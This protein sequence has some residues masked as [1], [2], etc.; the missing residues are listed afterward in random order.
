[1]NS[2]S[3]ILPNSSDVVGFASSW[4]TSTCSI[5]LAVS[6][7][8][9]SPAIR[10]RSQTP[11]QIPSAAS[12]RSRRMHR[13]CISPIACSFTSSSI[14]RNRQIIARRLPCRSNSS[15]AETVRLARLSSNTVSQVPDHVRHRNVFLPRSHKSAGS[16]PDRARLKR[17]HQIE[18][19]YR[20]TRDCLLR[21]ETARSA[22]STRRL[23]PSPASD[24]AFPRRFET[25]VLQQP[26]HQFLARILFRHHLLQ[27]RIPRQQ[28]FAT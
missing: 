19:S 24:A 5:L 17:L 25:F 12:T 14:A 8:R 15:R 23:L 7:V 11:L 26:I 1:M 20:Q 18:Q 27:L 10:S 9:S 28:H 22:D 16:W 21:A 13:F 3:R 6:F 2:C 4:R